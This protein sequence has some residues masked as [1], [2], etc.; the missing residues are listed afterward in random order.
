ML[1]NLIGKGRPDMQNH[2]FG[3][4]GLVQEVLV[5]KCYIVS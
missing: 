4:V 5:A 3:P 2:D 1:C